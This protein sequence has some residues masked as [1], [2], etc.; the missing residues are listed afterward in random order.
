[1][2]G[3]S[4]DARDFLSGVAGDWDAFA[5]ANGGARALSGAVI[6][7]S[8]W[9][10]VQGAATHAFLDRIFYECR[11]TQTAVG[12]LYRCD[13]PTIERV[14]HMRITPLPAGGLMICHDLIRIR[15]QTGVTL[16][17][18]GSARYRRCSQC[19]A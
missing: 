12:L 5:I 6:G 2:R 19:L 14:Y 11:R 17:Q 13:S 8:L 16:G 15:P 7:Q 18:L 3:Y 10:M 4:L 9:D 1:M